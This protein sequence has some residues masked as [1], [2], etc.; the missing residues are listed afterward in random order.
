MYRNCTLTHS[1]Q[2][3]PNCISDMPIYV[4]MAD[5]YCRLSHAP[6]LNLGRALLFSHSDY[7]R[8]EL[9]NICAFPVMLQDRSAEVPTTTKTET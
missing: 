2:K 5:K 8:I 6:C 3:F 1:I 4:L 9:V 7:S